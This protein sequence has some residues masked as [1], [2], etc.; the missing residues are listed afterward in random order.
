MGKIFK[1]LLKTI[2]LVALVMYAVVVFSKQEIQFRK[3][4]KELQ[5]Y[6]SMIDEENLRHEQ[7]I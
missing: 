2:V 6:N 5:S 3:Y 4:D 1:R 7:L